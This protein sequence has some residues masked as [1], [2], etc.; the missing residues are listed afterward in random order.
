MSTGPTE[1][2]RRSFLKTGLHAGGIAA[3]AGAAAHSARAEAPAAKEISNPGVLPT[4]VFGRTGHELPIFGHGGSAM[5]EHEMKHYGLP[6]LSYEERVKMVRHGYDRG[7]RYFDTA[8][9]YGDS[10]NVMG[11]ALRDVRNDVFINTKAFVF[12]P[13]KI[14]LSVESSLEALGTDYVDA[15]QIHGPVIERLGYEG[16][17]PIYEE[18]AKLREEG[19]LRFIG[20]SGHSRFEEMHKLLDTG[21]F[22]TLLLELGYF[23]KGYNTRHSSETYEWRQA[24]VAKAAEKN[25]AISA[26]K[27]FSANIFGHNSKNIVEDY[28]AEKRAQLPG[29]A[30]RYVLSDPRI[31]MLTIGISM[32]EDIDRNFA[33]FTGDTTYSLEDRQL[34]AD[35][36]TRA[37]QSEMVQGLKIV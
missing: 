21:L 17:M 26:M 12:A 14:R 6:H 11:E 35:F 22:D 36:S 18:L 24:C 19:L 13:D 3:L 31:H 37:Y 27:V 30:I 25:V 16:C 32:P 29:A 10:E 15:V 8:R 34:L 33:I 23:R 20:M 5:V 9:I 4:K 7:M 1:M 2:D 28:D